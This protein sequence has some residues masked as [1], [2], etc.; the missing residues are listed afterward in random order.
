MIIR[1]LPQPGLISNDPQPNPQNE[2]ICA[3]TKA[4]YQYPNHTTPYLLIAN[5][6]DTGHYQLNSRHI[7]VN[8]KLFYFLNAGDKLEI[9]FKN[10]APLETLLILFSDEFIKSW[11]SYRHTGIGS[12]LANGAANTTGNFN[13]PNIPFEYD[14][15][16][17]NQLNSVRTCTQREDMDAVL[18]DLLESFWT[19]KVNSQYNLCH[20]PA[21][22]KST[23]EE[24]YRRLLTAK[25]FIHDNFNGSPTIEDIAS[26]ACLDKFHFLKLFKSCYGITPHQYLVKLKLEHAYGLLATGRFT[27]MQV[28][29][30]VG[31][32]SQGTFC[33]L[34]KKYYHQLPSELLKAPRI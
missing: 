32:E 13:I 17:I 5:F 6:N 12:L 25:I 31:F 33:N 3:S 21:K 34:F 14:P 27:V 7:S 2:V 9:N 30:H 15:N 18:F 28:C 1:K 8:N 10:H 4:K 16:I 20:I 11:V 26:E 19:L 22:R 24:I 29:R 23:K